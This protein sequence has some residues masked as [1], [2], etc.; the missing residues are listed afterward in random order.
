MRPP[1]D[2]K[3]F[4]QTLGVQK[5]TNKHQVQSTQ[6]NSSTNIWII[7]KQVAKMGGGWNWLRIVSLQVFVLTVLKLCVL[8]K[9]GCEGYELGSTGSGYEAVADYCESCTV[10]LRVR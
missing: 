8:V 4:L 1:A 2:D 10:K 9:V 6:T 3:P 5:D 7:R